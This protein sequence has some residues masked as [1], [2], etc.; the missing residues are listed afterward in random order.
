MKS[1]LF[2]ILAGMIVLSFLFPIQKGG[3]GLDTGGDLTGGKC[4][5][6]SGDP[7]RD[8]VIVRHWDTSGGDL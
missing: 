5:A 2:S 7:V 6:H 1:T 4:L 8:V 3:K